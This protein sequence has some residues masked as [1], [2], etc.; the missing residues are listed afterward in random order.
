MFW[1]WTSRTKSPT[2]LHDLARIDDV[3]TSQAL[4]EL[5]ERRRRRRRREEHAQRARPASPARRR[6]VDRG[7]AVRAPHCLARP[8]GRLPVIASAV[9]EPTRRRRGGARRC[10]TGPASSS[11]V[12]RAVA[13]AGG[14]PGCEVRERLRGDAGRC[15]ATVGRGA[16]DPQVDPVVELEAGVLAQ[17]LDGAL[18]LARVALG[19]QLRASAPCR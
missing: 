16:L 7:G 9:I 18:E 10:S 11:T 1:L 3:A 12:A 5:V 8:A 2:T 19:A 6:R 17:V 15:A 14:A 4:R 13:S